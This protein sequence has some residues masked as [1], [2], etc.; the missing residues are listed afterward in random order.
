[1]TTALQVAGATAEPSSFAPLHINRMLTGLWTNSNPLRDAASSL[2]EEKFYGGRQDRL[3][4]GL[5]C[6]ISA[7]LTLHRRPGLRVYNANHFPPVTRF[8]SWNTFTLTDETVRVLAD[9]AHVVYDVTHK[10]DGTD[11]NVALWNKAAGAGST[12]FLGVGNALFFTNGVENK[13]ISATTGQVY[14]WGVDAP[15]TAP[16]VS[17]GPRPNPYPQWQANNVYSVPSPVSTSP[18]V[19]LVDPN[20][21]IQF[22][23]P[24]S[25]GT[26]GTTG[27]WTPGSQPAWSTILGQNTTDGSVTWRNIGFAI[28]RNNYIY[29]PGDM[30]AVPVNTASGQQIMFFMNITEGGEYPSGSQIPSWT[31]GIGSQVQDPGSQIVWQNMGVTLNWV[32]DIGPNIYLIPYSNILDFN[33]YTQR[34]IQAGKSGTGNPAPPFAI[35]PGA[36][37]ND[38]SIVWQNTG[39][40][41][42]AA[43]GP[44]QYGYEFMNSATNDLSNM[45]PAS[46]QITPMQGNQVT[47]QGA[48]STKPGDDKVVVFRTLQGGSTFGYLTTINMPP[49]GQNWTFVDVVNASTD[50]QLNLEWQGQVAGEGTPLPIGATCME[51]HAGHIFAA[52]GNVVYVSSGPDA[53]VGGSSGNAGFDTTFTCQSKITRFWVNSMGVAVFTVRDIYLIAGS[54]TSTDP[55]YI[56]RWIS[57]L[58]LLNYDAFDVNL[59]TPHFLTG[60]RTVMSLD[61]AAGCVEMSF[62]IADI[63][64]S[65]FNPYTS[66]LTFH[67]A[68]TGELAFFLS[69]GVQNWYRLSPVSAP[70]NGFNWNPRAQI[71]GGMSAVQSIEISPGTKALLVGPPPAGGPILERDATLNTDNG[72]AFPMY[73]VAGSIVLAA[74]GQLAGL[75]WL[76]VEC[77]GGTGYGSMPAVSVLLNEVNGTY[78]VLPRSRQDPPN[79]PP[80]TSIISNRHSALQGQN[81][82]WCRHY[83][84]RLDWPTE[85]AANELL[86]Y[87]TFGQ[88]WQELRNA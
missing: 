78:E 87:T 11:S 15:T 31:S 67:T 68:M 54:G 88:I 69:D 4:D 47:V 53:T 63:V 41:T 25:P 27:A 8:Y 43:T 65:Q 33:G 19:A 35:L 2:Y 52:V 83:K 22:W 50:A 10:S 66:Y 1:M 32:N 72:T 34:V 48:G 71:T 24:P 56:Q 28:Y 37:T 13:Q 20:G 18:F 38:G 57:N 62:P 70:D 79:L 77:F 7:R 84:L 17:Q 16:T 44:V 23:Q 40:Y 46:V 61:P 64:A 36:L 45:S 51:Y 60:N 26:G 76:T 49:A 58:P 59:T 21:N 42:V 3:V 5:N 75:A 86:A 39:A 81:P 12:Y 9:T 82:V 30:V 14:D 74:P 73:V 6:E 80:S 29:G 85:N 55:F